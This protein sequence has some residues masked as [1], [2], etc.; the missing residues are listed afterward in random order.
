MR[1]NEPKFA[2][3]EE[4]P[5]FYEPL[6]SED[7][8]RHRQKILHRDT[9]KPRFMWNTARLI[10]RFYQWANEDVTKRKEERMK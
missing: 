4:F 6:E 8:F 5:L 2:L 3:L 7:W 10:W 9:P 1:N